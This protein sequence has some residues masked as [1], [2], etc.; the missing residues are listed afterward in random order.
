MILDEESKFLTTFNTPFGRYC[1]KR[2]PFGLV[3]AQDIF[4]R[5]IDETYDGLPGIICIADDVVVYGQDDE[6]H[7]ENLTRM[8]ERTKERG[9]S[10]N[11]DK[12]HI[13]QNSISFY[14]H[15]LT[16]EGV[17]PDPSKVSAIKDMKPPQNI[18]QLL[19]F[20][21]S[22]KYLGSFT[23][24]LS[25]LCAPLNKLTRKDVDFQWG[26]EHQEAFEHIKDNIASIAILAY[27]DPTKSVTIQCDAS[28]EGLGAV[29]YQNN[30]P[31]TVASKTLTNT[32]QNYSNIEREMLAIVF[33]LTRFH[34]YTYGR[35]VI[36]ESDHKP[37]ESITKKPVSTASP[38]I[39]RML[40]KIQPYDY[41][42]KYVPGKKMPVPDML[43]RSP[44]PGPEIPQLDVSIG[45]LV[46]MTTSRLDKVKVATHL[47][48]LLQKLTH[49]VMSGWPEHR[50]SCPTDLHQFWNFRD[51]IAVHDGILMK[52]NRTIIPEACQPEIL[53]QIH[54]GHQGIEK[55]RLRT[56][57]AVYWCGIDKDIEDMV[58]RCAAC[59][60]HQVC[61]PKETIIQQEA[62][63][64]WEVLSTD[65]F[66]WNNSNYLLLVDHYSSYFVLRKLSSTRSQ[67]VI[68][69]LKTIFSEFGIPRKV[70]SDNGPQYAA[71][72]FKNFS[73]K[74]GF[75]HTTSSPHY[76]QANGKVERF[77]ATVKNT[78]QK[79]KETNEDPALA[80]LAVRNTP[81][82]THLPS[83]AQIMFQRTV[84]DGLSF[85]SVIQHNTAKVINQHRQRH[86]QRYDNRAR[87]QPDLNIGQSVRIQNPITKLWD[88]AIV[89]QKLA[90]PRSFEVETGNGATYR[91]NRRHINVTKEVFTKKHPIDDETEPLPEDTA[92]TIPAPR[93]SVPPGVTMTRSGRIIKPPQRLDC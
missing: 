58:K 82:A 92:I 6:T 59:Q 88:P 89:A 14:G 3:S 53:C 79:C 40:L 8:M 93:L 54:T 84:D 45:S 56:R 63:R 72:D 68:C 75:K 48:P 11:Y 62:L 66:F 15:I 19:S 18:N 85:K 83:P 17:K 32:E 36:V 64:P 81:I 44:L 73:I 20:L 78:L 30:K 16:S 31:V 13:K 4:Q 1:F 61:N 80:L 50:Q 70:I 22:A 23:P 67:D 21:S 74:Y 37:L 43:S 7:D 39:K 27:F 57:Q 49:Q 26:P 5:K 90:E 52:G 55:C 12:C 71:Q 46:H 41:S 77:V 42:V 47:D 38:R 29:L 87:D 51:E 10:L 24:D 69:K 35:H 60:H 9:L 65:L 91:R 25:N 76:H 34:H 2:L 28:M 86:V 33:A